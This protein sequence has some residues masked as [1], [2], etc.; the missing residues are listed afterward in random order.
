M[1]P[2]P[3]KIEELKATTTTP[4]VAPL[5]KAPLPRKINC[6]AMDK[7]PMPGMIPVSTDQLKDGCFVLRWQPQQVTMMVSDASEWYAY[8]GKILKA[9]LVFT[10]VFAFALLV[11][12]VMSREWR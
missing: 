2:S 11:V 5:T 9:N 7:P 10:A 6:F 12:L 3:K 4:A 1:A 8:A